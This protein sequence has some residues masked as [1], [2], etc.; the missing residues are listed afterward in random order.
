MG[1]IRSTA[2][3]RSRERIGCSGEQD[4]LLRL[5]VDRDRLTSRA[6]FDLV[7]YDRLSSAL[8]LVAIL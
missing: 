5:F 8:W 3:A 7:R 1:T 2:S 6:G 4:R